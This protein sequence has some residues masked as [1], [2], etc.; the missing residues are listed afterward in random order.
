MC[1]LY[2]YF[3]SRFDNC[4]DD[5][6][7]CCNFSLIFISRCCCYVVVIII[8][9]VAAADVAMLLSMLSFIIGY[10]NLLYWQCYISISLVLPSRFWCVGHILYCI[11][12]YDSSPSYITIEADRNI[13]LYSKPY[14]HQEQH[15]FHL[16]IFVKCW[17]HYNSTSRRRRHPH[18]NNRKIQKYSL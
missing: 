9:F 4:A 14:H 15:I 13:V 2:D 16:N 8:I 3:V 6:F 17:Y 18:T 11:I 1:L 7:L 10:L 12:R 5:L